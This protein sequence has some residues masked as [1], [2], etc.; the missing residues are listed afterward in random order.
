MRK[1]AVVTG[2]TR[3]IGLAVSQRLHRDGYRL[4]MVGMRDE[5][6][7]LEALGS[8]G[9]KGEDWLYIQADIGSTADRL[10]IVEETV[11]A[12]GRVDLLVNNAGV[13]P[14]ERADLLEMSEASWDRVL[15]TNAKGTMFLTQ[16]VAN[17]MLAQ[18]PLHKKRGTIINISSISATVS[19]TNRGEYCASKAAISMLTTLYA[20]RL[21]HEEIFVHEIRPGVIRTDM[22]STVTEKYDKLVEDGIFPIRRW[23]Q[24]SDVADAVAVFA[25]D[26]FRYTTGNSIEVDGGFHIRR[27]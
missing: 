12:W 19:S 27:L 26:A 10:R 20:D 3:G 7:C 17:Q 15:S 18:P 21:A 25:S 24:P 6:S 8:V 11:G 2:A 14:V 23:G 4:A 16:A 13:A 9:S 5:A 1:I 22:T